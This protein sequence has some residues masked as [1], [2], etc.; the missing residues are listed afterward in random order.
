M[1][2][3]TDRGVLLVE[4]ERLD[5]TR[6]RLV[7]LDLELTP[8]VRRS[9]SEFARRRE[10][11]VV[12]AGARGADGEAEAWVADAIG[13]TAT[14]DVGWPDGVDLVTHL[15]AVIRGRT[16]KLA[17]AAQRRPHVSVDDPAANRN[18]MLTQMGTEASPADAYEAGCELER[19]VKFVEAMAPDADVVALAH[20]YRAGAET[21]GEAGRRAG[22]SLEQTRTARRRLDRLLAK[23]A[24]WDGNLSL[25]D[26]GVC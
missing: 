23:L 13:D 4:I 19:V 8:E 1:S 6:A 16:A 21:V 11:M 24:R 2:E 9:M 25:V 7:R 5:A 18:A 17:R 3:A 20:A 22:L 12:G 26:S 14:G 15:R 10:R